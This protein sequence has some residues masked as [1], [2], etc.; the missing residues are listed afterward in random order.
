MLFGNLGD[1]GVT[2]RHLRPEVPHSSDILVL[3]K[4]PC[5]ENNH[6]ASSKLLVSSCLA[7]AYV[8]GGREEN[9]VQPVVDWWRYLAPLPAHAR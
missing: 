3:P 8:P 1:L 6:T 4:T 5:Q 7:L 2:K 9:G